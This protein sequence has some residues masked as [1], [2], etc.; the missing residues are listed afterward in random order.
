MKKLLL[1]IGLV[2]SVINI[3]KAQSLTYDMLPVSSQLGSS[4]SFTLSYTSTVPA[5]I[6]V[7]LY[8]F[9]VDGEGNL[10]QDWSTWQAGTSTSVLP[11]TSNPSSQDLT[12]NI[13]G[14]VALTSALPAGKTYVWALSLNTESDSWITGSQHSV[15]I[16][17][18]DNV[19]NDI[20]FD[21]VAVTEVNA[22]TVATISY[23]LS[24]IHI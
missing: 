16:L 21:G 7:A 19:V 18:S 3:A 4:A 24:L 17:A 11:A 14:S 6:S 22:G 10:T 5:K 13:P 12:L 9:N 23:N 15:S 2:S 8:I 20:Q 1:F